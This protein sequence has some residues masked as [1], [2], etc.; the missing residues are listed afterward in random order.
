MF[1]LMTTFFQAFT[2]Y[3]QF[4]CTR[5]VVAHHT[6]KHTIVNVKILSRERV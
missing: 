6:E 4:E 2:S 5:I 3:M 1:Y